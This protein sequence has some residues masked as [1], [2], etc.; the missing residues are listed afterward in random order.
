[1]NLRSLK[2]PLAILLLAATLAHPAPASAVSAGCSTLGA[3]GYPLGAGRLFVQA[4]YGISSDTI[5]HFYVEGPEM[6]TVY[7]GSEPQS[8]GIYLSG[9]ESGIYKWMLH[10]RQD[11]GDGTFIEATKTLATCSV[12]GS[13]ATPAPTS[14]PS[15]DS[16]F[17]RLS[18]PALVGFPLSFAAELLAGF[19]NVELVYADSSAP[20]RE[21]IAQSIR[22]GRLVDAGTKLIVTLSSGVAP[23]T[24]SGSPAASNPPASVE[25][26]TTA[27]A[28]PSIETLTSPSPTSVPSGTT[29]V[30]SPPDS[31]PVPTTDLLVLGAGLFTGVL[32]LLAAL[33]RRRRR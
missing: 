17:A 30:P 31:A 20:L 19:R 1:V 26:T 28:S 12:S 13:S 32:I 16:G 5:F 23:A 6:R 33:R 8:F 29:A 2:R 24:P 3:D 27:L 15:G 9:L 18:V 22:A 21:V 4:G 7:E 10:V 25:P 11:N 14:P